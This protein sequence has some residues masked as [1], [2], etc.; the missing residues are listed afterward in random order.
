MGKT[1]RLVVLPNSSSWP[2]QRWYAS[3]VLERNADPIV[4]SVLS[5]NAGHEKL[6]SHKPPSTTDKHGLQY[7]WSHWEH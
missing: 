6:R 5:A 1:T 3:Q 4:F 2:M 7:A